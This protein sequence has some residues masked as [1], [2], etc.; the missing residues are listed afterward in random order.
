MNET[1]QKALNTANGRLKA[2]K[3]AARLEVKNN[4]LTVRATLPPKPGSTK[5]HPFQQR[6]ALGLDCIPRCVKIAE[7]KARAVGLA[8]ETGSFNWEDWQSRP[9]PET[10]EDWVSRFEA[11]FFRTGGSETT[12]KGDYR[13]SFNKLPQNAPL[14]LMLLV[15]VAEQAEQN[16][17]PRQ[18]VCM[19]FKRLADFAG[20]E[21]TD[22]L[23]AIRGNYSSDE[24]DP[25]SLPSDEQ[26]VIFRNSIT[27]TGWKWVFGMMACY[28]LR[29]HEVF[30]CDLSEFPTIHVEGD[31]KTGLRFVWPL[32]PEWPRQWDLQD[33]KLPNIDFQNFSNAKIGTKVSRYFYTQKL[34]KGNGETLTA[35]ELRHCYSRRLLEFGFSPEFGAKMMGHSPDVHCRVYRRWIDRATYQAIYARM[36]GNPDRPKPPTV[37]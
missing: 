27:N 15:Q 14:T 13:Q 29:P 1:T 5:S 31:T 37:T 4:K 21:G 10:V 17:K 18:R 20:I 35:Y 16:S 24:V 19:A 22:Q 33:I 12:W 3:I 34:D 32:Y 9:R 7:E 8:L 23:T 6:I 11:E 28:G 26:L 36:I 30:K 25:R 2:A